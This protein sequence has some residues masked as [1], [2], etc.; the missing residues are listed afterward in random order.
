M[1]GL[2]LVFAC[3]NYIVF[4]GFAFVVSSLILF[5]GEHYFTSSLHVNCLWL[6][7]V[8]VTNSC[9][10]KG[11]ADEL[12]RQGYESLTGSCDSMEIFCECSKTRYFLRSLLYNMYCSVCAI[13]NSVI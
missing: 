1:W 9:Y 2:L 10:G 12:L 11:D 7:L 8:H 13:H 3:Q 4:D 5:A 6:T